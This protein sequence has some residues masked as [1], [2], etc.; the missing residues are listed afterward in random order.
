MDKVSV[1]E[2]LIPLSAAR[3]GIRLQGFGGVTI[4]ETANYRRGANAQGHLAYM[5]GGGKNSTVSAHYYVDDTGAIRCIPETEVAWHAGDGQ[6]AGGGNMTTVAIE[7]CEDWGYLPPEYTGAQKDVKPASAATDAE[8]A[9]AMARFTA[10]V[11]NAAQLAAEILQ[12]HGITTAQGYVHRHYDWSGKDCPHNIRKDLPVGWATFTAKVQVR[13]DALRQTVT[14]PDVAEDAGK[15]P[16][17]TLYRVQ[18][19]AF[20]NKDNADRLLRQLAKDGY[21]AYIKGGQ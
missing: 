12:R 11:D 8:K 17:D 13:L 2:R 9:D 3:P 15:V 14:P 1:Q 6:K 7:I 19:G 16:E 18:V 4:H 20:N 10:A 5:L 21:K